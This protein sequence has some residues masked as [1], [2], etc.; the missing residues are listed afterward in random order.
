VSGYHPPRMPTRPSKR[1][2]RVLNAFYAGVLP[3]ADDV[4][5]RVKRGPQK[6]SLVGKANRQWAALKGGVLRRNRRGMVDMPGGGKLPIG[7]S[8]P[9]ILDEIGYLPVLIT[10]AMVGRSLPVLLHIEDKTD[11]GVI[12]EHQ[13][14]CIDQLRDAGAIVGVARNVQDCEDIVH[15]WMAAMNSGQ[16]GRG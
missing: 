16:R 8:E 1:A 12:A 10:E 5:P 2:N 6:E 14:A 4:K 11:T 13:Q 15:R 3:D 9:L 7:L